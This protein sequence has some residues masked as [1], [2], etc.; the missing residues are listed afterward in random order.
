M[1][2]ELGEGER[3]HQFEVLRRAH[4]GGEAEAL[5]KA[6]ELLKAEMDEDE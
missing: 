2:S 1:G 6:R 4:Y 3:H 5:R